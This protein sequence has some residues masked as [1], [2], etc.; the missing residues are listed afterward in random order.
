MKKKVSLIR[1]VSYCNHGFDER[2]L[3]FVLCQGQKKKEREYNN[4]EFDNYIKDWSA[5]DR[6]VDQKMLQILTDSLYGC[7]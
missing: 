5:K 2:H 7:F 1:S 3:R 6:S 4:L